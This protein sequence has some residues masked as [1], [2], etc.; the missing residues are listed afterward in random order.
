[1]RTNNVDNELKFV[2]LNY[3]GDKT[4]ELHRCQLGIVKIKA[5]ASSYILTRNKPGHKSLVKCCTPCL[6]VIQNPSWT[7]HMYGNIYIHD[8]AYF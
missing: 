4:K 2:Y 5:F 7:S 1:M 6:L 3:W 8:N